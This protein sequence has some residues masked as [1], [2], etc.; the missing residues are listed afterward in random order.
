MIDFE[1]HQLFIRP[2]G[3]MICSR[4]ESE[5]STSLIL[6]YLTYNN[7]LVFSRSYLLVCNGCRGEVRVS[8]KQAEAGLE[9]SPMP[10]GHRYS[11]LIF[12]A[13]MGFVCLLFGL[14][15]LSLM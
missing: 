14:V 6:R 4:C 1:Q 3:K 10:F 5:Q 9:R 8:R 15:I 7:L 13:A 11:C 2:G 12:L